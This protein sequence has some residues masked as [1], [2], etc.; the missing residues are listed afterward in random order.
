MHNSEDHE[1]S[2]RLRLRN[3]ITNQLCT[4]ASFWIV[5]SAWQICNLADGPTKLLEKRAGPQ[6]F[7]HMLNAMSL[8]PTHAYLHKKGNEACARLVE[9]GW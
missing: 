6:L 8:F 9:E 3:D 7:V 2:S 4:A 1:N 5:K